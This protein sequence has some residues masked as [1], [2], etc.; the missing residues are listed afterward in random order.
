MHTHRRSDSTLKLGSLLRLFKSGFFDSWLTVSYLYKYPNNPGVLDYL[1]NELYKLPAV[2]V[3]FYLVQ[4]CNLLTYPDM[5]CR[6]EALERYLL[7]QCT[8]SLHFAVQV[9]WILQAGIEDGARL[10]TLASLRRRCL[11][12]RED[13]E[14]SCVNASRVSRLSTTSSSTSA[15]SASSATAIENTLSYS[16]P[17]LRTTALSISSTTN[18]PATTSTTTTT[19]TTA[20]ASQSA[21]AENQKHSA[22]DQKHSSAELAQLE[23][24]RATHKRVRSSPSPSLSRQHQSDP[25][26]SSESSASSAAAVANTSSSGGSHLSGA[27]RAPARTIK[28]RPASGERHSASET[29]VR[30]ES[31]RD[32]TDEKQAH[33]TAD[34]EHQ[35]TEKQTSSQTARQATETEATS[36]TTVR[37]LA[38]HPHQQRMSASQVP[39]S[40]AS[41]GSVSGD[42][43]LST[44]S[45]RVSTPD[46]PA[47]SAVLLSEAG[48][49]KR[50]SAPAATSYP[51]ATQRANES[52][53]T[54]DKELVEPQDMQEQQQQQQQQS[55]AIANQSPPSGQDP[56]RDDSL[57]ANMEFALSKMQRYEYF[58][59]IISFV[60]ELGNIAERVRLKPRDQRQRKLQQELHLLNQSLPYGLYLPVNGADA[61]AFCVVRVVA[62]RGRVFH[63]RD[64]VPYLLL[65]EVIETDA[66]CSSPD[67]YR[68]TTCFQAE[69]D[70]CKQFYRTL[71]GNRKELVQLVDSAPSTSSES[72]LDTATQSAVS[73]S[74]SVSSS[75]VSSVSSGSAPTSPRQ[76]DSHPL[77]SSPTSV[78]SS[79]VPS[80]AAVPSRADE[81]DES[82]DESKPLRV[83]DRDLWEDQKKQIRAASPVGD[84]PRWNCYS[85]IVKFGD[86]CR[87]EQLAMQLI[88]Q[89]QKIFRDAELPLYLR[90]YT[91]MVTSS[92]SGLIETVTDTASIHQLK[93]NNPNFT[94]L[95][96]YFKDVYNAPSAKYKFAQRN[97]VES[98]AGY[99]IVC[100][101][102]QIKDRHNGNILLDSSGHVVHID[103]GFM[104]SNSPGFNMNFESA[105]FKLTQEFINVMDGQDSGVFSY[106][107]ALLIRGFI[108]VRKHADK[109]IYLVEMM[110]RCTDLPC[111]AAAS[112]I[113]QLRER[114]CVSMPEEEF[115]QHVEGLITKS[116]DNWSTRQYDTFQKMSN[117]ILP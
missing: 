37:P 110:R 51:S 26:S 101:L 63:S 24:S 72:E 98:M 59:S 92:D 46:I 64:R 61:P 57:S 88:Y 100:Y 14:I 78:A 4:I 79:L 9:A 71:T 52:S 34:A 102:L 13:V 62:E 74:S 83:S 40:T 99:S 116:A 35:T 107:K 67:L 73:S 6:H 50:D 21:A 48:G 33:D 25:S 18:L 89:F 75:S 65:L 20:H 95:S 44:S 114:F 81:D 36:P 66:P 111:F 85:W 30:G 112:T 103:F 8:R 106:F 41:S 42:G 60:E 53:S 87:Q 117:G 2:E 22:E 90:P 113:D 105:P 43:S 23:P 32:S 76:P 5:L 16:S 19:T 94:S 29:A 86:D 49:G 3:E 97:F 7:D 109:V 55:S 38:S 45:D 96:D 68:I 108:E 15:S 27:L 91:I 93:K 1:A 70:R 58:N 12:L 56:R 11:Q 10:P 115:V 80:A 69:V 54:D 47:S 28:A 31:S 104:L 82:F 39:S 17:P 84:H 77:P